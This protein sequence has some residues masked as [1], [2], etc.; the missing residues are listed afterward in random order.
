MVVYIAPAVCAIIVLFINLIKP[1]DEKF[2]I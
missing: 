1:H 2:E